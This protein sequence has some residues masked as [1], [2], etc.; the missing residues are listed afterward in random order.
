TD[1]IISNWNDQYPDALNTGILTRFTPAIDIDVTD[2]EVAEELEALAEEVVGKSAVRIGRSPKRAILYRTEAPFSKLAAGFSSPNGHLHKVEVLCN[3]QQIIVSGTHP[4]TLQPY[5]WHGGEPGPELTR[6]QLPLLTRDKTAEFITAAAQL[7]TNR[8]WTPKKTTNGI[9]GSAGSSNR[10]TSERERAYATAAMDRCTEEL[11]R[12]PSGDRNQTLYKKAF[13]MGTMVAKEWIDRTTVEEELFKA[14]ES[15]G[16]NAADGEAATR[17]TIKSG[18]SDGI[19][20]PH[21]DL[22]KEPNEHWEDAANGARE[23]KT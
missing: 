6:D 3:G 5:R 1:K 11:A 20:V 19:G 10:P 16:L 18:L 7:M 2:E 22:N 12:T 8:G 15:C 13:R 21:P 9:H 23:R 14:A 4:D 17:S